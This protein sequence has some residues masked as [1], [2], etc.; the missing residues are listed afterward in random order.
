[1]ARAASCDPP[2][3]FLAAPCGR[4]IEAPTRR[5]RRPQRELV[6]EQGRQLRNDHVGEGLRD[7][8]SDEW[9]V[10]VAMSPHLRDGYV[11]VPIRNRTVAC[12]GL[13]ADTLQPVRR[14]NQ[15]RLRLLVGWNERN[16][17]RPVERLETW[18]ELAPP[19]TPE[20]RLLFERELVRHSDDRTDVQI[21]IRPTVE[22]FTDSR[23]K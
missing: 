13:E 23:P 21:A 16:E 3:K 14:W 1:V 18:I 22:A 19:P 11:V 5:L 6:F 7:G 20:D 10:E 12:D 15:D 4:T 17:H 8:Q 9:I 2:E